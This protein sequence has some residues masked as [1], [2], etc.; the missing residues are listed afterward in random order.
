VSF[1]LLYNVDFNLFKFCI[2]ECISWTIK[3]IVYYR[4]FIL[5]SGNII[6]S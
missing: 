4:C 3:V 2:T 6:E 1:K 5:M